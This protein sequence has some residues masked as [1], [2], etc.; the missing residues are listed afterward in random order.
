MGLERTRGGDGIA[1][2]SSRVQENLPRVTSEQKPE[3]KRE[4]HELS[5]EAHSRQKKEQVQRSWG[6]RVPGLLKEKPRT[7]ALTQS[8]HGCTDSFF[9]D[10]LIPLLCQEHVPLADWENGAIKQELRCS[11]PCPTLHPQIHPFHSFLPPSCHLRRNVSLSV[12]GSSLHLCS[13]SPTLVC[14]EVC[15]YLVQGANS[16][17]PHLKTLSTNIVLFSCKYSQSSS[18]LKKKNLFCSSFGYFCLSFLP[19]S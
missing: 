10:R 2:L 9:P 11:P 12:R 4:N 7:Q 13:W 19:F 15:L 17:F 6:E 5:G 18:N 14:S 16:S 8:I 3:E 1:I